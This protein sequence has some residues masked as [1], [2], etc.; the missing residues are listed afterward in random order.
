MGFAITFGNQAKMKLLSIKDFSER[1]FDQK[2]DIVTSY[3]NYITHRDLPQ[4]KA[5]LY[6]TGHF[7]I[8]VH[9]S[10]LYK[11]ILKIHAFNDLQLIEAYAET[12][13]LADLNF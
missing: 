12:I 1:S 4:G 7:F 6:H 10:S 2:C 11:K 5:Y 13:S 3:S 9:Y 8:E